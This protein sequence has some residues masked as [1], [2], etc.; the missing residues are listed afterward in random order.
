L[1]GLHH[2]MFE[3]EF[4]TGTGEPLFPDQIEDCVTPP[5]A[6]TS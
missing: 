5:R 3:F 6:S 4:P 1:G 2:H